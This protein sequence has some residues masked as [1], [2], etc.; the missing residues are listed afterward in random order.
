MTYVSNWR[1]ALYITIIKSREVWF[2]HMFHRRSATANAT[3]VFGNRC[4]DYV[5]LVGMWLCAHASRANNELEPYRQSIGGFRTCW[6][7]ILIKLETIMP[8]HM[9]R[10]MSTTVRKNIQLKWAVLAY[11][12]HWQYV[13]ANVWLKESQFFNLRNKIIGFF[14]PWN[15]PYLCVPTWEILA[16]PYISPKLV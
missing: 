1:F 7:W 16:L 13:R 11:S 14:S 6:E 3:R 15:P 5:A 2:D 8:W 12:R 9:S 4:L 10:F